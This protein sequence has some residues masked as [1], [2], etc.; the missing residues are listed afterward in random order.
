MKIVWP[1]NVTAVLASSE[2]T[3]GYDDDNVLNDWPLVA[4]KANATTAQ[5]LTITVAAP[6]SLFVGYTNY[7][8]TLGYTAKNSGGSAVESGNATQYAA[9]GGKYHYWIDIASPSTVTSVVLSFGVV[10]AAVEVGIVRAGDVTD[11]DNP[12]YGMTETYENY[13]SHAMTNNGFRYALS[14]PIA[15][16]YSGSLLTVNSSGRCP[17]IALGKQIGLD[18]F[19][20]LLTENSTSSIC[21]FGYFIDSPSAIKSWPGYN[22]TSFNIEEV[23]Q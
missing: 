18:P 13:G 21:L 9:E 14:G 19:A 4:W 1:D 12:E 5:T 8:G 3:G 10:S 22:K 2:A 17:V 20:V 23:A 11:T 16:R 7:S 6:D 15:P